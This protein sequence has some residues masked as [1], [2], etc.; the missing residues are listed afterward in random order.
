MQSEILAEDIEFTLWSPLDTQCGGLFTCR[1]DSC[2]KAFS[3]PG[4]AH[5]YGRS[6]VW[7]LKDIKILQRLANKSYSN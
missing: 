7:I 1:L 4:W 3:H 6:P 2:V 5:L